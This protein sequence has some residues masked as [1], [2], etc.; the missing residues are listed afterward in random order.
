MPL[1][2]R[3]FKNE[4]AFQR[5]MQRSLVLNF[6]GRCSFMKTHG[7]QYSVKGAPDLVGHIHGVY[8]GIELKMWGNTPSS[9]QK[10]FMKRLA[11]S[12]AF[13]VYIVYEWTSM[14]HVTY[15]A[16]TALPFST[17]LSFKN[18]LPIAGVRKFEMGGREEWGLDLSHLEEVLDKFVVS[19]SSN[20]RYLETK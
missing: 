3:R 1:S 2:E 18:M 4:T 17:G 12:G 5:E 11:V 20:S 14:G 8:T 13:G 10:K 6:H 7:S 9:D 19:M 15:V 16:P